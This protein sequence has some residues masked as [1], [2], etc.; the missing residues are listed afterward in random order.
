[1]TK[2]RLVA[3]A[4]AGMLALGACGGRGGDDVPTT[5]SGDPVADLTQS[6]ARGPTG[7]VPYARDV[8][9]ELEERNAAL[10]QQGT[11]LP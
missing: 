4:L 7:V 1:M 10:D 5:T 2:N 3:V 8:T 6:T 9:A 11:A